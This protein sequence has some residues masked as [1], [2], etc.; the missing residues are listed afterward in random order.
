MRTAP[1]WVHIILFPAYAGVI[2][3]PGLLFFPGCAFPRLRGGDPW[4]DW[5]TDLMEISSPPM[6]G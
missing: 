6:P 4:N 2:L 3:V 5:Y 1:R